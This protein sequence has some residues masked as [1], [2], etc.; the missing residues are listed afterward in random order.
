[1]THPAN[2]PRVLHITGCLT[3]GGAET[4][5]RSLCR[6]QRD[7]G[8]DVTI[9]YFYQIPGT[10]NALKMLRQ[11]GCSVHKVRGSSL[12]MNPVLR[13]LI[14]QADIIHTHLLNW[15]LYGFI[16][17]RLFKKS[18][19]TTRYLP[20]ITRQR[21]QLINRLTLQYA[22][23]IICV[24]QDIKN[25]LISQKSRAN[26]RSHVVY[27]GLDQVDIE[28]GFRKKDIR[29]C[30]SIGRNPFALIPA[31]LV[32]QKGLFT[33]LK[34]IKQAQC[35]LKDWFFIF[36]GSG[37]LEGSLKSSAET[38]GI[39]R[40]LIFA[41][42]QENIFDYMRQADLVILPSFYEGFPMALLEALHFGKPI[43]TSN[44]PAITE[45]IGTAALKVP[46]G[47]VEKLAEALRGMVK[48]QIQPKEIEMCRQ[49][50]AKFSV[51]R[52]TRKVNNIYQNVLNKH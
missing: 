35:D 37:P 33:L 31:R 50:A 5:L 44:I 29:F 49:Q 38:A 39:S 42:Y 26:S 3:G 12:F 11:Y 48:I 32:E 18:W 7:H 6:G 52:M 19:I 40:Q 46:P 36:A 43:I 14:L 25:F 24:S 34:A 22:D 51:N 17:S 13:H 1:M 20:R 8:L 23:A 27:P 10:S 45:W 30:Y 15:E 21:R 28:F 16:L 2:K 4:I 9:F 41:G 47:D